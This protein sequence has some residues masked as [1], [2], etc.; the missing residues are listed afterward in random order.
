MT[1]SPNTSFQRT[2]TAR[3]FCPLNS[4]RSTDEYRTR[5]PGGIA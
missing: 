2:Q 4:D 1:M 3:L 5:V